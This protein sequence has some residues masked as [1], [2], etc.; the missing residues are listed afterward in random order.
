MGAFTSL[1][2]CARPI[3]LAG[4]G[5]GSSLVG[6]AVA[7]ARAGGLGMV[8]GVGG[9]GALASLLDAV[10]AEG[11]GDLAVGVNFLV[12]FLDVRAVEVAAVRRRFVELFWGE[13]DAGLVARIHEARGGRGDGGDRVLAAWQVGSADEAEAAVDAGCDVVVVQGVEAGGHV[14]ATGP[15]L[16]L[17]EEVRGRRASS[18]PPS[19][20]VVAAGGLGTAADVAR[21][22]EAGAD[23]VRIGTR[24]LAAAESDAH[25]DY[26]AR[27]VAAGPDDTVLTTAFG[28]GW[29][30]APHRVLRSAVSA[31]EARGPAQR[32]TPN[33]PGA[34]AGAGAAAGA[35]VE[36]MALYAGRSV[37]GVTGRQPAA[38][39]VAE[40]LGSVSAPEG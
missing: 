22:F 39:I 21:A 4:M 8:S 13:P 38:A 34:G 3:Q 25:P 6:L 28:E 18:V 5:G 14:R 37:G 23:A 35:P 20:P 15:L 30:D 10:D 11:D 32:W 36:A 27:L 9:A 17:L 24:F 26:V 1:V 16:A 33:W 40:L 2:G 19:V 12:P 29:P 7:V 31:G